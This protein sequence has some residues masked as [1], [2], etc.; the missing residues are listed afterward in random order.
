MSYH[1]RS[2]QEPSADLRSPSGLVNRTS[3]FRWKDLRAL[4]IYYE[5]GDIKMFGELPTF[6]YNYNKSLDLRNVN[7][8]LLLNVFDNDALTRGWNDEERA[9][10]RYISNV[11]AK[12]R[13][14]AGR[15]EKVT[16]SFVNFLLVTLRFNV[17]PFSLELKADCHFKVHN[18]IVTSETDFSIWKDKLY[19]IIDED[20]H[21][22]NVSSNTGWGECQIAGELLASA[23]VNHREIQERYKVQNLFAIR[24]IG[25]RFTFYRAEIKSDYLNSFSEGFPA[26]EM[27]IYRY[28]AF[29]DQYPN[30]IP[31][32]D[33]T[34]PGQRRQILEI[35]IKIKNFVIQNKTVSG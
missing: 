24:V 12:E 30:R 25:T 17:Y 34:D 5:N 9:L 11:L 22:H 19:V 14:D 7:K 23:Y 28:P 8:D 32:L 33:Y 31:C 1:T 21:I 20:K 10:A 13:A 35:M 4:N 15:R 2:G 18:K 3:E 27:S 6:S 29:S 16:D 26:N